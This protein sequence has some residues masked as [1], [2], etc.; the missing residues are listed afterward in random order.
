MT[1]RDEMSPVPVQRVGGTA[2]VLE[3]P[4]VS[5]ADAAGRHADG[6]FDVAPQIAAD[7]RPLTDAE[8]EA[9]LPDEDALAAGIEAELYRDPSVFNLPRIVSH[10]LIGAALLGSG[11]LLGVFLVNQALSA[12]AAVSALPV[13]L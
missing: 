7:I 9:L 3:P 11:G 5:P 12:A 6:V 4:R 8:R 10:P 2:A 13:A 1:D